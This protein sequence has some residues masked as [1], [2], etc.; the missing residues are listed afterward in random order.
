MIKAAKHGPDGSTILIGL[1]RMNTVKL[2]EGKPIKFDGR[3]LGLPN[4][5]VLIVGGETEEAIIQELLDSGIK[6]PD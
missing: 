3:K 4:I 5:T 6:L 1:S 2:L